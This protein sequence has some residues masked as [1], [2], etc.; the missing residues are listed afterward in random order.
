MK[1]LI[2]M[3]N[4]EDKKNPWTDED[5]AKALGIAR[6]EVLRL[7]NTL[8]ISNSRKRLQTALEEALEDLLKKSGL[9]ERAITQKI[10][11]L[12]FDV[13]RH[14]VVNL[15][16]KIPA[17]NNESDNSPSVRS[18]PSYQNS[19]TSLEETAFDNIAGNTGSLKPQVELA[20]AAILYPP[21]G[22]HTLII[23]DTGVGKSGAHCMYKFAIESG[24]KKQS[25][26]FI[27]FNCADY[28]KL[29]NFCYHSYLA[30]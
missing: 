6:S 30:M 21:K 2:K 14:T 23:G 28:A 10:N 3:I 22:L 1:Q 9:S 15:L 5:L 16:K 20:K 11:E 13:S 29:H 26:P 25:S 19:S 17:Y 27:V 24:A 12:G 4:S 18:L 8:D 7:R